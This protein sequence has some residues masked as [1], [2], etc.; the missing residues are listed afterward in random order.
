MYWDDVIDIPVLKAVGFS[1]CP[2]DACE[3]VKK[4]SIIFRL[5]KAVKAL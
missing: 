1:A 5:L 3:D 2:I 4:P